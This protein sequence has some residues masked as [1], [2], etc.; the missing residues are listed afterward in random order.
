[1]NTIKRF[2]AR[3]LDI[4]INENNPKSNELMLAKQE[5]DQL[6]TI[7]KGLNDQVKLYMAR[8]SDQENT[9]KEYKSLLAGKET[10]I[11]EL[12]NDLIRAGKEKGS[13]PS[14]NIIDKGL[15]YRKSLIMAKLREKKM[16]QAKE[17]LEAT[18]LTSRSQLWKLIKEL[19]KEKLLL[20]QGELNRKY[21]ILNT[22]ETLNPGH[23][24]DQEEEQKKDKN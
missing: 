6:S 9:L 15:G 13:Q 12:R 14:I 20:V 18:K 1:M 23:I 16:I 11:Q 8:V 4:P 10:L 5:I 2:L 22:E 19:E 24:E 7:N 21:I 17:L 3:I